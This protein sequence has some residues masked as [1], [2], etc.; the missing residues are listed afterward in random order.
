MMPLAM[1]EIMV[2]MT[3][4]EGTKFDVS[5]HQQWDDFVRGITGG[6]TVMSP[7]VVG[8]WTAADGTIYRER[9]IPVHIACTEEQINLIADWTA[10]HYRQ[11]A[12]MFCLISREVT[13]KHY[14]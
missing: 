3:D 1:Y 9:P 8:L 11:L 14:S 10:T 5:Y 13:I 12:I 4:N 2:P 6:L 7:A